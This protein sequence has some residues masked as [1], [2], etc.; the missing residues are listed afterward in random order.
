MTKSRYTFGS[1]PNN[2][3]IIKN[4]R[5]AQQHAELISANNVVILVEGADLVAGKVGMDGMGGDTT[6]ALA[7]NGQRFPPGGALLLADGDCV[8]IGTRSFL[9]V[10]AEAERERQRW[11]AERAARERANVAREEGEAAHGDVANEAQRARRERDDE[12]REEE[13]V[14]EEEEEE[15]D[16]DDDDEEAPVASQHMVPRKRKVVKKKGARR[17]ATSGGKRGRPAASSSTAATAPSA[18]PKSRKRPK[19]QQDATV[20]HSR[21][22]HSSTASSCPSPSPSPSPSQSQSQSQSNSQHLASSSQAKSLATLSF[23]TSGLSAGERATVSAALRRRGARSA[24]LAVTSSSQTLLKGVR[25]RV[26]VVVVPQAASRELAGQRGVRWHG[27]R[28]DAV[29]VAA[30][31]DEV[32][33]QRFSLTYKQLLAVAAGWP[34]ASAPWMLQ[35]MRSDPAALADMLA[36]ATTDVRRPKCLDGVRVQLLSLDKDALAE[37]RAVLDLTGASVVSPSHLKRSNIPHVLVVLDTEPEQAADGTPGERVAGRLARS[38]RERDA[39]TVPVTRHWVAACIV[40]GRRQ[41]PMDYPVL[42]Q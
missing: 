22:A 12:A 35:A 40:R 9:Y 1:A 20:P 6:F 10:R 38:V 36:A 3:I 19:H 39:T 24:N 41:E 2:D 4:N 42:L 34:L 29:S 33:G 28:S 5:V 8:Q 15:E 32:R 13:V 18:P 27:L 25:D 31:P 37:Y 14:E 23:A 17:E 30:T 7:V 26:M 21:T 16:D 11:M